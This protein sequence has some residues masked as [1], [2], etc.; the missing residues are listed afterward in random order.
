MPALQ[1]RWIALLALAAV[2]PASAGAQLSIEARLAG[3]AELVAADRAMA[4]ST[5]TR[6]GFTALVVDGELSSARDRCGQTG[7]VGATRLHR[8]PRAG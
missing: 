3:R 7:L 5:L 4:D 6:A 2:L 1:P 8:Q